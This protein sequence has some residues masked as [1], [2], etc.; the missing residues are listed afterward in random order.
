MGWRLVWLR[1]ERK[2]ESEA[3]AERSWESFKVRSVSRGRVMGQGNEN[4]GLGPA[5]P[6]PSPL[7]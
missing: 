7:A 5:L 6:A 3:G 2:L 4:P 1:A